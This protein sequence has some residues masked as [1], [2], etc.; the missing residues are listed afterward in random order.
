VT[1]QVSIEEPNKAA[2]VA[3]DDVVAASRKEPPVWISVWWWSRSRG[4]R[5]SFPQ[6]ADADEDAMTLADYQVLEI[7]WRKAGSPQLFASAA[8]VRVA[9]P[10]AGS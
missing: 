2:D 9:T 1:T 5:R 10:I 8:P 6:A 3:E 7:A 4:E